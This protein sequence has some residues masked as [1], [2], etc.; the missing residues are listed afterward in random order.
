MHLVRA[1]HYV[2][3]LETELKD[4]LTAATVRH[5]LWVQDLLILF[6]CGAIAATLVK[7]H[8]IAEPSPA[9]GVE[10]SAVILVNLVWL[11]LLALNG[12]LRL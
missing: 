12:A 2:P 5:R 7:W 10:V 1:S 9:V 11:A 4:S 3:E 6:A 8:P